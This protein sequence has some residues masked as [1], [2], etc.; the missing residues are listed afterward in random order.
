[1]ISSLP[2]IVVTAAELVAQTVATPI[3]MPIEWR[4]PD[5]GTRRRIKLMSFSRPAPDP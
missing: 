1:M 5:C 3:A 2:D 4:N